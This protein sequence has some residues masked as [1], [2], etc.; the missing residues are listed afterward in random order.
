MTT[1]VL[2]VLHSS[3]TGMKRP[4]DEDHSD[5]DG[6]NSKRL[7]KA[8]GEGPFVELRFLMQ[9][10]NAG[11]IIGKGGSNIKRLRQDVSH[12]PLRKPFCEICNLNSIS[13]K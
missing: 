11:A 6:G 13:R 12:F 4:R 10:K 5:M 1:W 8:R 2:F 9:S 3:E 7:K